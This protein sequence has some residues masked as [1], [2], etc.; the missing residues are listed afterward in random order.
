MLCTGTAVSPVFTCMCTFTMYN[1][2]MICS[3]YVYCTCAIEM[4]NL[5]EISL[6]VIFGILDFD[7]H[8]MHPIS[9]SQAKP[10]LNQDLYIYWIWWTV[11]LIRNINYHWPSCDVFTNNRYKNPCFW[12]KAIW[13]LKISQITI[14]VQH[15]PFFFPSLQNWTCND[16]EKKKPHALAY[17]R[18]LRKFST[19]KSYATTVRVKYYKYM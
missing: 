17:F 10:N 6:C 8:V 7:I 2:I 4:D 11:D 15:K 12:F 14:L 13:I 9:I 3:L 16:Q 19:H 5:V 18:S 1:A